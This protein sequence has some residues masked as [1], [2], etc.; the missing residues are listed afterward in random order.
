MKGRFNF[1]DVCII[2]R[3]LLKFILKK[4]GGQNFVFI[5]FLTGNDKT[6]KILNLNTK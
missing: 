4:C 1:K 3:I 2:R 6:N 5:T